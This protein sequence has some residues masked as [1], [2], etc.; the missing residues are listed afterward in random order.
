VVPTAILSVAF[1][2]SVASAGKGKEIAGFVKVVIFS[3]GAV[4]GSAHGNVETAQQSVPSEVAPLCE[5]MNDYS[6]TRILIY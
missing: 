1:L 6:I 2:S 3:C 4:A 5:R